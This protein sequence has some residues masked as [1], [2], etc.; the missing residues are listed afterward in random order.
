M[1]NCTLFSIFFYKIAIIPKQLQLPQY[2][3]DIVNNVVSLIEHISNDQYLQIIL[4]SYDY[5]SK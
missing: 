1:L 4:S 2:T 3:R 5:D